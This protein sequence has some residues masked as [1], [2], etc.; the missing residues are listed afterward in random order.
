[1]AALI[2]PSVHLSIKPSIHI[3]IA[4]HLKGLNIFLHLCVLYFILLPYFIFFGLNSCLSLWFLSVELNSSFDGVQSVFDLSLVSAFYFVQALTFSSPFPSGA[5][6]FP[7][8]WLPPE[9]NL[10]LT[11]FW[12][13]I[14]KCLSPPIF[15]SCCFLSL[16]DSHQGC[17]SFNYYFFYFDFWAL[18]LFIYFHLHELPGSHFVFLLS[19][20]TATCSVLLFD[21]LLLLNW[22]PW[23]P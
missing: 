13:S 22:Q 11:Q 6:P 3:Y 17:L 21:W 2:R 9:V 18:A 19:S 23:S 1:M 20:F 8:S 16:A 12:G 7:Q 15:L 4:A 14:K 10:S 5:L